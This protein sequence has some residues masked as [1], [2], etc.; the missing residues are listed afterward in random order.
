MKTQFNQSQGSTSRE[1]NKEA[2][3]RI[4][5]LKKSQVG[6]LSTTTPIDTYVILFDKETQTCWYRGTATGTPISWTISDNVM[7]LTTSDGIFNLKSANIIQNLRSN[8]LPGAGMAGLKYSGTVADA[9][10]D[11]YVD[12]LGD[13]K[14][15]QDGCTEAIMEAVAH[16]GGKG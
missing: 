6:Y 7:G 10:V 13:F 15:K 5:G 8:E 2:I 14:N 4:F 11:I 9:L 1:T 16:W 12:A 3:A